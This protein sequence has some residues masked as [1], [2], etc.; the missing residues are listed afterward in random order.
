M[1]W[2]D[3]AHKGVQV[4]VAHKRISHQQDL[5][6]SMVRAIAIR[7]DVEFEPIALGLMWN[8]LRQSVAAASGA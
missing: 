5:A 6:H 8:L 4:L 1:Q 3:L 2:A 7:T